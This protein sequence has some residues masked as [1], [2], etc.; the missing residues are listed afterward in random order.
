[1]KSIERGTKKHLAGKLWLM[2][3]PFAEVSYICL[4]HNAAMNGAATQ[5]RANMRVEWRDAFL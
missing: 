2:K 5:L 4:P 1:M 3:R